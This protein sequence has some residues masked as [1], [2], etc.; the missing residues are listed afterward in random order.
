MFL[1]H[2]MS[3]ILPSF[4]V[5]IFPLSGLLVGFLQT[6]KEIG[7]CSLGEHFP[8]FAGQVPPGVL[9][10]NPSQTRFS[11]AL[12]HNRSKVS[13]TWAETE[14]FHINFSRSRSVFRSKLL[15]YFEVWELFPGPKP[16]KFF[17]DTCLSQGHFEN[18]TC[19]FK[20]GSNFVWIV[21]RVPVISTPYLI[22]FM[23][24]NCFHEFMPPWVGI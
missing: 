15:E 4:T 5:L 16:N 23:G 18:C 8:C 1:R 24:C 12:G 9:S 20:M 13:R 6:R 21:R 7:W 19:A 10:H 2:R 17:R 14:S 22:C 11:N 3:W